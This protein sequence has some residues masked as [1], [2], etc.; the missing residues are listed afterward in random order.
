MQNDDT[1][2]LRSSDCSAAPSSPCPFC[3][4]TKLSVKK[5]PLQYSILWYRMFWVECETC[6]CRGPECN[7]ETVAV[8][9]WNKDRWCDLPNK[10]PSGMVETNGSH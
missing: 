1:E 2:N 8:T 5:G 10:L 3:G 7:V 9:Y 4:F 6:G